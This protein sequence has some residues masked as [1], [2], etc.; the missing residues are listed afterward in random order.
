LLVPSKN[1]RIENSSDILRYLYGVYC[2]D[3]KMERVLRPSPEA[4]ELEQKLDKLGLQ[5]RRFFYT[6]ALLVCYKKR[7][8]FIDKIWQFAVCFRI[9]IL[10][11]M[12]Y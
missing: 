8:T 12:F 3:P 6:H 4:L 1:I 2:N 11:M 9:K 10:E 5:N 7:D